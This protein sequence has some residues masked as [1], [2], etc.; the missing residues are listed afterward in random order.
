MNSL[1]LSIH[2]RN[3]ENTKQD[4]CPQFFTSV[5]YFQTTES[6]KKKKK[7]LKEAG[8]RGV[9]VERILPVEQ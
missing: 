3:S 8:D 2:T 6:Q 1:K 5:D 7:I 4:K 9:G